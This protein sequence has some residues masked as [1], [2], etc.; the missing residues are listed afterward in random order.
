MKQISSQIKASLR[1]ELRSS[2]R[3]F[4]S[5]FYPGRMILLILLAALPTPGKCQGTAL[6]AGVTP[7]P[8]ARFLATAWRTYAYNLARTLH[9][10]NL[11]GLET[12]I[13][14][15]IKSQNVREHKW[16][17]MVDGKRY[18]LTDFRLDGRMQVS[19]TGSNWQYFINTISDPHIKPERSLQIETKSNIIN[20]Y[21]MDYPMRMDP[22]CTPYTL[23][24]V[25]TTCT[26]AYI[27]P[28]IYEI[29]L[30]HISHV[31]VTGPVMIHGEQCYCMHLP[32]RFIPTGTN[33]VPQKVF[34][35]NQDNN[36]VPWRESF[37]MK[38]GTTPNGGPA[39]EVV[40]YQMISG[41]TYQNIWYPTTFTQK[42]LL[43]S[44]LNRSDS[45]VLNVT[46]INKALPASSFNIPAPPG[47]EIS[48][49][50]VFEKVVPEPPART[51]R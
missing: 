50:G 16:S 41:K 12:H 31:K 26:G 10:Y 33:M 5:Q 18:L 30:E 7:V 27:G 1:P 34:M 48:V 14:P 40:N 22:N 23:A 11:D 35:C 8:S 24:D 38:I 45:F 32:S 21:P 29:Y 25:V 20:G 37:K 36:I 3:L 47:T 51:S 46:D 17:A 39:Y 15:A 42:M 43:T 9:S 44:D 19:Y 49:D 6:K 28:P 2:I 4:L 13:Y